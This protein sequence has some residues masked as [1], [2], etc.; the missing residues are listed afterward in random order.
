MTEYKNLLWLWQWIFT[1]NPLYNDIWY[2]DKTLYDN[3]LIG[4]NPQLKMNWI[5]GEVKED[6]TQY[7]K[8]LMLQHMFLGVNKGKKAFYHIS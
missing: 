8:K 5:I 1:V 3:S 4:T 7:S 6:F 2:I